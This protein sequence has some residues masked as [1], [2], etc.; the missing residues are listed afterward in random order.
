[1]ALEIKHTFVSGKADGPDPTLVNASNWNATHTVTGFF[2]PKTYTGAVDG[3][4]AA[5]VI[6]G[7][8][9][10]VQVFKN[11]LLQE[12]TQDYT[13]ATGGGNSTITFVAAPQVGDRLIFWGM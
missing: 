13:F 6:T 8:L 12:L 5:F 10:I 9:T 3:T 11:G 2:A 7:V 4:N 1:M